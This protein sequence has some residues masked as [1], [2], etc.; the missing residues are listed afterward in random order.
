MPKTYS[1][2]TESD[3]ILFYSTTPHIVPM[4]HGW[5]SWHVY[6]WAMHET[7]ACTPMAICEFINYNYQ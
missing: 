2:P 3:C 6:Q 5:P 7:S 1:E 4:G